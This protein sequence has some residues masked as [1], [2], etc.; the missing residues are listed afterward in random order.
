MKIWIIAGLVCCAPAAWGQSEVRVYGAELSAPFGAVTGKVVVHEAM[1]TFVD[2]EKPEASFTV[3]KANVQSI[4]RMGE[5]LVVQLKKAVKDRVGE[6][7]RLSLRLAVP[8]ES[9]VVEQ[10][11]Q[12]G[13]AAAP[14]KP[15]ETKAETRWS[16]PARRNKLIGGTDGTL[17]VTQERVIFESLDKAEDTRRWE[18][19]EIKELK[20]K[21]PYEVEIIPFTGDKYEL[22]LSG[23]G[24]ETEQ[25]REL[26]DRITRARSARP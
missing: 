25:F 17:V 2:S 23:S 14:A 5:G 26:V 1:L 22:K 11:L 7:N 18:F 13:M 8:S 6:S 4:T 24:M 20:R 21:N 12:Q 9:T 10:W 16:F 19:K 3:D 15:G